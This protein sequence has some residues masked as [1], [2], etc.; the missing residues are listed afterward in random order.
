MAGARWGGERGIWVFLGEIA[1]MV[2]EEGSSMRRPNRPENF[3]KEARNIPKGG[4]KEKGRRGRGQ[5][6]GSSSFWEKISNLED[7][8]CTFVHGLR[9][10]VCK[11]KPKKRWKPQE[12]WAILTIRPLEFARMETKSTQRTPRRTEERCLPFLSRSSSSRGSGRRCYKVKHLFR[13][14]K[15]IGGRLKRRYTSWKRREGGKRRNHYT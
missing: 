2:V 5:N 10:R 9:E 14:L 4:R 3:L 8:L 6:G 1:R 7:S 15:F 11:E 12:N 13:I